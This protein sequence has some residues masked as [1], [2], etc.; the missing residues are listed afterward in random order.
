MRA[1]M[2]CEA[3]RVEEPVV[4]R[5]VGPVQGVEDRRRSRRGRA[6]DRRRT[7]RRRPRGRPGRGAGSGR[8]C[9]RPTSGHAEAAADHDGQHRQR[10]RDAEPAGHDLVEVG[11]AGVV[12]VGRLPAKPRSTKRWAT[13][14]S[15]VGPAQRRPARRAGRARASTSRSGRACVAISSDGVV[16]REVVARCGDQLGEPFAWPPRRKRYRATAALRVR[17]AAG[18]LALPGDACTR[19]SRRPHRTRPPSSWAAPATSSPTPS[20]TTRPTGSRSS[21]GPPACS[22][23]TTSPSASRTTRGSSPSPGARTTPGLYYTA[24]SS[25]LTVDEADLHHQ[26][27]RRPG[28]HHVGLQGRRGRRAGRRHARGGDPADGRRRAS[29]ASSPTRTPS[30][31][32]RPSRWPTRSPGATCSTARAPPAGRRA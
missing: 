5:G 12:V 11:V 27:L 10:D 25:R 9:R 4:E 6:G 19:T 29:T 16:E 31:A 20:S 1:T 30:P 23:A 32:T 17:R 8:A 28:V 3:D 24:M 22:P 18:R 14:P 7:G 21:S 13:R 26:R 2:S 15:S